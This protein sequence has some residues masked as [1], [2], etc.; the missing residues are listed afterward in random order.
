MSNASRVRPPESPAAA[1]AR[2][3]PKGEPLTDEERACV[4]VARRRPGIP[5]AEV[6]RELEERK[7]RGA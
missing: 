7:R 3:A 4:E 1:A 5:H 2:N 6:M